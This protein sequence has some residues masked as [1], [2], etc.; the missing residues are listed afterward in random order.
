MQ[1]QNNIQEPSDNNTTTDHDSVNRILEQRAVEL[2]QVAQDDNLSIEDSF[3]IVKFLIG[4]E[5]YGIEID[6]IQEVY[7]LSDYTPLP[8]TP[9]FVVGIINV[10][11]Q[12]L[13][14]INIKRYLGIDTQGITNLNTVV[15]LHNQDMEFGILVDEIIGVRR[16]NTHELQSTLPTLSERQT[17][18]FMGVSPDRCIVLDGRA[19]LKAS[20]IIVEDFIDQ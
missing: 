7:P 13:S 2:A 15:I 14:I 11:G 6:H 4:K 8:S 3:D 18:F 19:L 12:I 5:T 17:D 9:D 20:D 10:R 1:Q 16:L